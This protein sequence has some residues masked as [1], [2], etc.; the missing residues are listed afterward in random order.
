MCDLEGVD[1][2]IDVIWK[3]N[4]NLNEDENNLVDAHFEY[5]FLHIAGHAKL[6]DDFYRNRNSLCYEIVR[7]DKIKFK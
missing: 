3:T 5:F 2:D 1:F 7:N 4:I 6:I